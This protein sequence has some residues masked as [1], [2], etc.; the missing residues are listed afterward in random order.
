[1]SAKKKHPEEESILTLEALQGRTERL[2]EWVSKN[3]TPILGSIGTILVLALVIGL[4]ASSRND[5]AREAAESLAQARRDYRVAMGAS[6]S[7][8]DI[9]EPANP[10]AARR[11]REGAVIELGLVV[12]EYPGTPTA[13]LAALD[14][15]DLLIGL[16]RPEEAIAIWQAG[17]EAT[18]NAL[19]GMLLVRAAAQLDEAGQ[20][21]EA[22]EAYTSAS[23]IDEYPL[24]YQALAE[25]A[26]VR[27]A[28]GE[29]EAAVAMLQQ[30]ETD[31]PDFPIPDHIAMLLRELRAS[32]SQ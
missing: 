23:E 15:G 4:I 30:L 12:D 26:R 17:A 9:A 14:L 25:A 16:D 20:L 31:A 19:R 27:A 2:G 22:A 21:L 6:P 28:A 32:R 29:D 18:D 3:P 5:A 7:S 24:R 8:I 13:A 1:M 10:E 11:A